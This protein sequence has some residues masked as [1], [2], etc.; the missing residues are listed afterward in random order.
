MKK[1]I[2]LF[3][4][5]LL[6][7]AQIKGVVKDSITKE[8]IAYVSIWVDNKDIGTT[9][10]EN[11]N[12]S[13]QLEDENR[14]VIFSVLGYETKIAVSSKISEVLLIQ[15]TIQIPEIVIA[16]PSKL[17]QIEIGDVKK[18]FYLPEPQNIPWLFARKFNLDKEN[19]DIKYIKELIYFTKS[20]VENG[21]F[22]ARVFEVNEDGM[23]GEDLIQDEII[24]KVKKGKHKTSVD[25]S[26]YNLQIP[27]NGIII[28]FESLLLEQNVYFQEIYSSNHKEK[29][30]VL[31]YA[32]HIGY[33][34]NQDTESY[35]KRA[36]KWIYFNNEYNKKY[37]HPIPAIN[38]TLT[39]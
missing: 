29:A 8:P 10:D 18:E 35:N 16:T 11:G 32:P 22:R 6:A 39:N 4:F 9:T 23:P 2:L 25:V 33:F 3:L 34:Y 28:C 24:V 13:L 17:K 30:K 21:I 5:S 37:K 12:F 38:I 20:E 27:D 36:G 31:N 26:K 15:K 7:N 19:L 1:L 14:K